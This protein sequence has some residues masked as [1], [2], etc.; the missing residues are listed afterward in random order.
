MTDAAVTPTGSITPPPG[1]RPRERGWRRLIVGLL[2]FLLLPV[3]TPLRLA[4]PVTTTMLLLVPALAACALVGWWA[5]GRFVL[6]LT[7]TALAGWMVYQ[8]SALNTAAFDQLVRGWSLVLAASFGLVNVFGS[9]GSFFGRALSALGIAS[10][11]AVTVVVVK[12]GLPGRIRQVVDAEFVDRRRGLVEQWEQQ[13][14]T[15]SWKEFAERHPG[16]AAMTAEGQRQLVTGAPTVGALAQRAFPALLA[17]ESLAA[18][19]LAWSLYHRFSRVR[20]GL[21]LAPLREFRFNDQL[22]WG[23]VVGITLLIVSTL[24]ELRVPGMNLVLFFGAL[25][26]LRGLGVLA[27]FLNPGWLATASLVVLSFF[28]LPLLLLFVVALWFGLGDTWFDWRSRSRP[29]T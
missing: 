18:L 2:A 25:Y 13:T 14:S 6:A 5:G 24:S 3:I 12:P 26:A 21:P 9:R 8:R 11:V 29:T 22:V 19:A 4:L 16:M 28:V 1:T 17:L 27:W 7:W 10:V 23:L 15:A 20:I